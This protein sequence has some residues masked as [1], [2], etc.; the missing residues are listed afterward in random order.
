MPDTEQAGGFLARWSERKQAARKGKTPPAESRDGG[1]QAAET[2]AAPEV[3]PA[4]RPELGPAREPIRQPAPV[5]TD[6]DMPPLESL[7]GHSDYSGFL[8]RGVSA[9]LRRQALARLFHSP[10]LNLTDCLDD[11]PEDFTRFDPLGD[12]V[13]A[14]M[15]HQ[16]GLAAGRLLEET[17]QCQPAAEVGLA[18]PA[19][20]Y[21]A[22]PENRGRGAEPTTDRGAAV[23]SPE[24]AGS[25]DGAAPPSPMVPA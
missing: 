3:E 22:P 12:L 4:P 17:A 13:T 18:G 15:R 11:F 21:G 14:D 25:S 2:A 9:A 7:D 6:A 5:L 8:S 16:L 20:D 24:G 23:T 19:R 10:H 1:N